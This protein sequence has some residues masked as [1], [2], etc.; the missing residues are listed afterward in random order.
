MNKTSSILKI[1]EVNVDKIE[2]EIS[3]L[4][5]YDWNKWFYRQTVTKFPHGNTKTYPFIWSQDPI[6]NIISISQ[7]NQKSLLWKLIKKEI[8]YLTKK[9]KGRVVKCMLAK[10]PSDKK[11]S[12]HTDQQYSLV[13]SYR[14]HFP[15]KADSKVVFYLNSIPYYLERGSWYEIN[16]QLLH[17]VDNNS[18]QDRIHLIVDILSFSFDIKYK[19]C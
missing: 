10:L 15:I 11:I 19:V 18:D 1:N 14:F 13:N 5:E 7:H 12:P 9:Y 4:S 8:N 16:N 2:Q 17:S 6:N 3:K